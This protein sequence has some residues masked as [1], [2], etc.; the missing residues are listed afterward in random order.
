MKTTFL[1]LLILSFMSLSHAK[2]EKTDKEKGSVKRNYT[3]EEFQKSVLEEVDKYLKKVGNRKLVEFSKELVKKDQSLKLKEMD[4]SKM[5]QEL[6]HNQNTFKKKIVEFQKK[7]ERFIGCVDQ[8]ELDKNKRVTHMVDVISGMRPQNAADVLS[9]QD[10]TIS[11]LILEKLDATKVSKIFNTMDKEIS[12]R[13]Q[14]Q[15]MNMK[16]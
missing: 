13:L 4:I 12:A 8:K 10:S 15:Y 6:T 2:N 16:K 3:E 7:Q 9:V 11:V 5:K 1:V 14:K